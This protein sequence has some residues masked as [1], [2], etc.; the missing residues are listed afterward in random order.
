MRCGVV[1][2]GYNPRRSSSSLEG[3]RCCHLSHA[4]HNERANF[5]VR[6]V[7]KVSIESKKSKESKFHIR[8]LVR[9]ARRSW[10]QILEGKQ[11][12]R[13]LML[14]GELDDTID[15]NDTAL[16]S[17]SSDRGNIRRSHSPIWLIAP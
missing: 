2:S 3:L 12:P 7:R 9:S 6:E 15:D 5:L 11:V 17:L 16:V 14:M 10:I 1:T 13:A 8:V 4:K